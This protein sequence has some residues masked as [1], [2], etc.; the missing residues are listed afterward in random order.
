MDFK[1]LRDQVELKTLLRNGFF[2]SLWVSY[3][4]KLCLPFISRE[5]YKVV[6]LKL[7]EIERASKVVKISPERVKSGLIIRYVGVLSWC[8]WDAWIQVFGSAK[9]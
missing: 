6:Q 1:R 5:S 7:I 9:R 4:K 2:G 8:F 3:K